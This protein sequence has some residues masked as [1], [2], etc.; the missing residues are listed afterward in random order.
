MAN[1]QDFVAFALDLLDGVGP[2]TAR[3]MFGGHGLYCRG[4]MFAL[5]D[6]DELFLKTDEETR[7]RFVE[8][9]CRR[10]TIPGMMEE[11][12]YFQPPPE[13]HDD[14]EAMT[15][16]ARLALDAALRARAR[17]AAK[18]SRTKRATGAAKASAPKRPAKRRP[19]GITKS[20]R[21]TASKRGSRSPSRRG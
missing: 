10:W 18:P 16:W 21:A 17:K 15:P 9:G 7:V 13:A 3:R 11:T 20:G 12:S 6:D 2:V 1:S 5:L 4:V 14:P 8:A 19:A